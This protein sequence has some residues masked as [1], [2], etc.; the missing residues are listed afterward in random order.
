MARTPTPDPF[1]LSV[2]DTVTCGLG[3]AIVI[4]LYA[5]ANATPGGAVQVQTAAP[6][7]SVQGGNPGTRSPLPVAGL[8]TLVFDGTF[9]GGPAAIAVTDCEGGTLPSAM[10]QTGA[11]LRGWDEGQ[12]GVTV[13]AERARAVPQVCLSAPAGA[14]EMRLMTAG[15]LRPP[16]AVQAGGRLCFSRNSD[17]V[18]DPATRCR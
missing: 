6:V 13:W 5:A 3:G 4:L 18:F 14:R 15:A 7:V 1:G 8:L 11:G 16:Q 2:L 10:M 9:H 12:R 17:G